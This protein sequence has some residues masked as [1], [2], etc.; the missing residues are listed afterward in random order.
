M[1]NFET[2]KTLSFFKDISWNSLRYEPS[3]LIGLI[4]VPVL[5]DIPDPNDS[6][7][8]IELKERK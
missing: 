3:P 1:P 5:D 4:S 8:S 2:I 7:S 6:F